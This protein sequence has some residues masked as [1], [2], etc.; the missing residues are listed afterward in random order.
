ME[1]F[2]RCSQN[3]ATGRGCNTDIVEIGMPL[4]GAE[5]GI[6]AIVVKSTLKPVPQ[7]RTDLRGFEKMVSYLSVDHDVTYMTR[8]FLVA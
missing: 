4:I 2:G 8:L 7:I 3:E 1:T 5:Q 6:G